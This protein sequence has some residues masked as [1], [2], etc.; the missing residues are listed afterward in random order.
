MGN[1]ETGRFSSGSNDQVIE[2][3]FNLVLDWEERG[4]LI[5]DLQ[6]RLSKLGVK[7]RKMHDELA[8]LNRIDPFPTSPI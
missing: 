6:R 1:H 2:K 3:E 4:K 5:A 8:R 7:N